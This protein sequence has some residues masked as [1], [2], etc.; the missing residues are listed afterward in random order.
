M[1]AIWRLYRAQAKPRAGWRTHSLTSRSSSRA[2]P[3]VRRNGSGKSY[4]LTYLSDSL[5][6][7]KLQ[8]RESHWVIV[9]LEGKG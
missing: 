5:R 2:W 1:T 3:R 8:F 4:N 9:D 6:L 7:D